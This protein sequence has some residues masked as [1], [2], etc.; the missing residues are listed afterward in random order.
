MQNQAHCDKSEIIPPTGR[1]APSPSGRLHLGN[2]ACSLLAWLSAKS[3]G[4]RIVLRIE[5]LDAERCPRIYADLLEQD[6]DWLGLAWDEGG[7]TGGPNGPYYQ[8]ECAEIYTASYKKLEERGLVYPCF[9][10][11]AQLHAA[12]A[13]HTSDGNVVYPGTCRGLTAAEIE[14]KRKKK[15]PAYRLMVPDEDITFVDGCMGPHT[16][17]LLH[18]CGD[19]YLRRADGV[20]AYQLAVVV[21]DARMG[22]TEVVRG[23]DLLSSTA[24]QL[25]L[26]RLLGL[27]AP[28]FAHCPLLLAPDG[29]RLSKRD[30]DQSLENLREKYTA[31]EIVGK[32]AY[33]YGLQPEPAPRTP[34]S[35]I[36]DFSW[37]RCQS[38]MSACR[39]ICSEQKKMRCPSMTAHFFFIE[40]Q[41]R[42]ICGRSLVS[43]IRLN[44]VSSASASKAP[45]AASMQL[46]CLSSMVEHTMEMHS[47]SAAGR[48]QRNR[49]CS[50]MRQR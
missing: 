44:A 15:A 18:D 45:S 41:M 3:Q 8:S 10:S 48:I 24:R 20:F 26:Y 30:G 16:E 39:R 12:S 7:S 11:R 2:L 40:I 29:R 43:I 4:G 6:L 46:C 19:F 27:Q 38:R 23:A 37:A 9:C 32:L 28:G 5:D 31:Q 25:C 22:V 21:D 14:E 49:G 33:A 47:T 42:R 17:N 35:L 36:K 13:P 34:E 1:F 50:K